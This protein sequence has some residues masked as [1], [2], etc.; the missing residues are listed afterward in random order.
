MRKS[1]WAV[2]TALLITMSLELS[3]RAEEMPRGLL[4]EGDFLLSIKAGGDVLI[5]HQDLALDGEKA[6][7]R[8]LRLQSSEPRSESEG[9]VHKARLAIEGETAWL[10]TKDQRY[11]VV[12][13]REGVAETVTRDL[14][15]RLPKTRDVE[16][17]RGYGL[18][19]LTVPGPEGADLALLAEE[20]WQL[21]PAN[22]DGT[23]SP[24]NCN[25]CQI[26]GYGS[27]ACSASN[28]WGDCSV[29]C[30]APNCA[31]C[32]FGGALTRPSCGCCANCM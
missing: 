3:A 8:Y 1:A 18:S 16:L 10:V 4:L 15:S 13:Q 5:V 9:W 14:A 12:L 7:V 31:C 29:T 28:E 24:I 32:N 30:Y 27:Q 2:I 22:P 19:L 17:Y 26:G 11:A 21:N 20:F 25:S 23:R 6:P